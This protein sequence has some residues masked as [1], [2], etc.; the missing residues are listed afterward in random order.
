M[1]LLHRYNTLL[2]LTAFLAALAYCVADD[3]TLLLAVLAVLAC[4]GAWR[5]SRGPR[6]WAL[7]RWLINVLML[8]AIV[9]ATLKVMSMRGFSGFW[10]GGSA[11]PIVSTLSQFLVYILLAKLFDRRT[12]R[13]EGQV[14]SL[15]IFVVVGA[16]LTANTLPVGLLVLAFAPCVICSAMFLQIVGGARAVHD[17]IAGPHPSEPPPIE[18]ASGSRRR[19]RRDFAGVAVLAVVGTLSLATVAF[20]LMPRGLWKDAL[21]GFGK[22]QS[23]AVVGFTDQIRLGSTSGLLQNS[24]NQNPILRVRLTDTQG[25]NLGALRG[26]L[27]LR[28]MVKNWYQRSTATW[29]AD[30]PNRDNFAPV[31]GVATDGRRS[32]SYETAPQKVLF[33]GE[34]EKAQIIVRQEIT[35]Q[36][37]IRAPGYFFTIWRPIELNTTQAADIHAPGRDLVL[38]PASSQNIKAY[39]VV[40]ALEYA[41]ENEPVRENI[42]FNSDVVRSIAEQVLRDRSIPL[43]ARDRD[44]PANR[45]AATA[46]TEYLR[47][48]C[49][50]DRNMVAPEAGED[51]IEMFLTRTRRGH[52]EYFASAMVAMCH[53]VG[54]DARLVGG[55][56]ATEFNE[57][58]GEYTVRESNAHAWAEVR[59]A[60]G[61]WQT[62]DPSPPDV[63]AQ[64]HQ[65]PTGII[66]RLRQWYEAINFTWGS[67]V[68]S[69]D[70]RKQQQLVGRTDEWRKLF[71]RFT[72]SLKAVLRKFASGADA[73]RLGVYIL[74]AATVGWIAWRALF[75]FRLSRRR[76]QTVDDIAARDPALAQLLHQAGFY[77]DALSLLTRLDLGKPAHLPPILHARAITPEDA[78]LATHFDTVANLY[79]HVRF[80][81]R[82]LTAPE[83]ATAAAALQAMSDHLRRSGAQA[84]RDVR[85]APAH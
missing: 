6:P 16:V 53:S 5:T 4:A 36:R 46:F 57:S 14:L 51:P 55:Y 48:T 24:E 85:N 20:I 61:R 43:M 47:A 71:D 18:I 66:A 35:L 30:E 41:D 37:E 63:I 27:Y 19:F 13:D 45:R 79:Y 34:R 62:Y 82:P 69:F 38:R 25:E 17:S 12:A 39:T 70:D 7:P 44:S 49:Q 77:T 2:C 15:S 26:T 40:S 32:H 50:Y 11:T 76:R 73:A 52:C 56:L 31:R 65:P 75:R 10:G 1:K 84:I 23:G 22:V 29:V 59:L 64:I 33:L 78:T 58:D 72:S 74:V 28:G 42:S 68:V 21:G 9:D 60:P 80:G 54:L 83:L 81:R 8:A 67:A 3:D